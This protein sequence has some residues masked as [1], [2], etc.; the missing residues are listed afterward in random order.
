MFI[1]NSEDAKLLLSFDYGSRIWAY[2]PEIRKGEPYQLQMP[3]KKKD[4]IFA[5]GSFFIEACE[6]YMELGFYVVTEASTLKSFGVDGID[7]MEELQNKYPGHFLTIHT[8]CVSSVTRRDGIPYN[9]EKDHGLAAKIIWQVATEQGAKV[10]HRRDE[11]LMP[12][13]IDPLRLNRPQLVSLRE[14]GYPENRMA[15]EVYAYLPPYLELDEIQQQV[16]GDGKK[17]CPDLAAAIVLASL[18]PYATNRTKFDRVIGSYRDRRGNL[19]GQILLRPTD[20]EY[21]YKH[22]KRTGLLLNT[23]D[24]VLRQMRSLVLSAY[25]STTQNVALHGTESI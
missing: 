10:W 2:N 3:G 16:M 19:Y 18:E 13:K 25:C 20:G 12:K 24:R 5:P 11:T 15:D 17:Y 22:H 4:L 9:P 23:H 6:Q 8:A 7:K 21:Q 14:Q 1:P